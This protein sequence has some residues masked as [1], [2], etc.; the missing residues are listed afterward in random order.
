MAEQGPI[1]MRNTGM[2]AGGYA[3]RATAGRSALSSR[4]A[5]GV[6]AL[7]LAAGGIV[8]AVAPAR[9]QQAELSKESVE[10]LMEYA[11]AITP[12]RFTKPNGVTIE[13]NR[14]DRKNVEVP[15][16]AAREII[17]VGRLS[18][19]AQVCDLKE[20]HALN[21]RT[22]MAREAIKKKWSEAQMVF[23]NQLHLVTVM[24]LTGQLKLIEREEG[25][26]AA[27]SEENVGKPAT[28]SAEQ[29]AKV[30]EALIAYQKAGPTLVES[31]P[32]TAAG[33]AAPAVPPA[34]P[35][36]VPSKK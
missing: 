18:A 34:T 21:F 20:E 25:K 24:L 1:E 5:V 14:N 3:K 7:T 26:E 29:K 11:W 27:V 12:D 4:L 19:H 23:M 31:A 36:A 16:D 15:L 33:G 8:A 13:I 22:L 28:C 30:K 35:A 32:S 17:R 9:A 10:K 6:F 2:D